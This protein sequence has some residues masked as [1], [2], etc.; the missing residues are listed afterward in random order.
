MPTITLE[1]PV[2]K[3]VITR[4]QTLTED[5]RDLFIESQ[6]TEIHR[7]LR[8]T[9]PN[10]VRTPRRY[11]DPKLTGRTPW[12]YTV[13]FIDAPARQRINEIAKAR[14]MRQTH[15]VRLALCDLLGIPDDHIDREHDTR[16]GAPARY[17]VP[18]AYNVRFIDG[19]LFK[20]KLLRT[21]MRAQLGRDVTAWIAKQP[22]LN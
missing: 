18:A 13:N 15:L 8:H 5:Q 7:F 3:A 2:T 20:K 1:I 17:D 12:V 6:L 22:E 4:W 11:T 19:D 10:T 9:D 21:G 16:A 14:Q